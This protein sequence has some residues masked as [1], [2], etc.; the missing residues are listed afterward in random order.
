MDEQAMKL[1][2]FSKGSGCG[3]KINPGVLKE[4]L[5][6]LTH[7]T[8]FPNLLVGNDLSDDCSVFDLGNGDC[9]LQTVDFFTPIVDDP[10]IYGAVAASNALSDIWAMG[11]KV[12]MANAVFS[13]PIDKLP[14]EIGK[15]VLKGAFDVCSKAGIPLAGGHSIDGAE[16]LMGLSVT[17]ICKKH[18][19]KRN[20]TAQ[21]G[22][23]I[24][25][26]K[27]LGTGM[28][29]AAMKRNIISEVQVAAL[30]KNILGL[31]QVGQLLG[32]EDSVHAMT[33]ITG[34]GLAGHLLEMCR[35]ANLSAQVEFLKLPLITEAKDLATSF[36]LPDN[37][38]RNWNAY[39][40]EIEMVQQD[41]FPWLVDPQ[42]NGGLLFA[43][44]PNQIEN[45]CRLLDIANEKY[46]IVGQFVHSGTPK[47]VVI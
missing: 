29:A 12:I 33:D 10:Y 20:S 11:G 24:F 46:S 42:T 6:G 19:L 7:N 39:Q 5:T 45:V 36:V 26:T 25:M 38:M 8:E 47:L 31:N 2:G 18:Q 17:G 4:L 13:W 1:T 34:F 14:L 22:D 44:D 27:S 15:Q 3:C 21:N 16:P 32:A 9:L 30:H 43:V 35:A 23:A 37:A 41:A 40:Q 28:L